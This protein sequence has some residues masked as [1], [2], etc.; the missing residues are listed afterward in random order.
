MKTKGEIFV[1]F[2]D[3]SPCCSCCGGDDEYEEIV[4]EVIQEA[5]PAMAEEDRALVRQKYSDYEDWRAEKFD[6]WQREQGD[7]KVKS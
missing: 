6:E 7:G 1:F 5:W 2:L 4:L 3:Q